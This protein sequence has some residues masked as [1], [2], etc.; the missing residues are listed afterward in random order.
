M[1]KIPKRQW[2]VW[3]AMCGMIGAPLDKRRALCHDRNERITGEDE[4]MNVSAVIAAAGLSSRMRDFK[5]LLRLG[6]ETI[7]SRIVRVMREAG[8]GEIVVVAGYRGEE[9][10][11]ELRASGARVVFNRSYAET[12]MLH[13]LKIGAA[14]L[15]APCGRLI[16]SPGD[17]PLMRADTLRAMMEQPGQVVRP[18]YRGK[19]GH[20]LLLDAALIPP[21]LDYQGAGGL[22]GAVRTLATELTDLSVDDYGCTLDAD[23]PE[24]MLEIRRRYSVETGADAFWPETRVMV[25]RGGWL[26]RPEDIQLLEMIGQ[27]G[28]L[29]RACACVHMSY[30]RGWTRLRDM[31]RELGM[32]L[33]ERSAGGAEGGGTA[34]TADCRALLDACRRYAAELA[35]ESRAAFHRAF[36]ALNA[37]LA[38]D[39]EGKG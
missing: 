16:L 27:T 24:D 21:L 30:T 28:S 7:I 15:K 31:E 1:T 9:L 8:A 39:Q 32:K 17:V 19:V 18:K 36:D 29:R 4:R 22:G 26:L 20:P 23:T 14:S 35:E 2:T 5:P 37:R 34:L 12:E 6:E 13:S 38:R 10:E 3:I 25:G 33:T 11:R